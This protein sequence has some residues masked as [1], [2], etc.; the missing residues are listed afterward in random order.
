MARPPVF[1]FGLA[2]AGSTDSW[3]V[4]FSIEIQ[5]TAGK[6]YPTG[7]FVNQTTNRNNLTYL[8]QNSDLL[9]E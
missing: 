4:S 8:K 7:Q 1:K 6:H 5:K 3:V 9:Y 2:L